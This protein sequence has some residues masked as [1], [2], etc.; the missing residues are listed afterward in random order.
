MS[1]V[2]SVIIHHYHT[3]LILYTACAKCHK[4]LEADLSWI[5]TCP[6]E[7]CIMSR[8]TLVINDGTRSIHAT[9]STLDVETFI[10]FNAPEVKKAGD[11]G[12]D[13]GAIASSVRG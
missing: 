2:Y 1:F 10:P 4:S 3:I 13:I 8:V 7:V 12:T 11:E 6:A 5:V 9:I